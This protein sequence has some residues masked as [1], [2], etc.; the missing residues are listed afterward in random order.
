MKPKKIFIVRHGESE[1]NVDKRVYNTKPDYAVTLTPNG[2]QQALQAGQELI[3]LINNQKTGFY[4]SPYYRTRA[5][6]AGI[7][8]SFQNNQVVFYR[9]D[10]RLREHEWA[11]QI[12]DEP[13][14]EWEKTCKDYG[15]FFFRFPTGESAA[16]AYLRVCSFWQ[17]FQQ[18]V[19]A[20][21]FPENAVIVGHG[22]LNRVLLMRI[23]RLT[24]EEFELLA[25]PQNCGIYELELSGD[26]YIMTHEPRKHLSLRRKY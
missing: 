12:I 25:N 9:E 20:E 10:P 23:L 6:Y 1:G 19:L 14:E 13:K 16:D 17:D 22:M 7:R 3:A 11:A 15:V 21:N 26:K 5:T 4:I 2:E 18:D 24:V 8:R